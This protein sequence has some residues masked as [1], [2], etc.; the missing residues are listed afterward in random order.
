[1]KSINEIYDMSDDT[2]CAEAY[3]AAH[4]KLTQLNPELELLVDE[5]IV[6]LQVYHTK[7][8][9]IKTDLIEEIQKGPHTWEDAIERMKEYVRN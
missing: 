2:L 1:M 4:H 8:D 5:L 6:R 9:K 3:K 7:T